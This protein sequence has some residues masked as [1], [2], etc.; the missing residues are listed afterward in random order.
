MFKGVDISVH[1][2]KVNYDGL[3][4]AGIE[5]VIIKATEGVDFIDKRFEEHYENVNGKFPYI[6]SYHY[7]SEKT[8]PIEQANDYYE[9]IKNKG[10]N[11]RPVLD[12][13]ANTYGRNRTQVTDRALLF[14]NQLQALTGIVPIVYTYVSFAEEYLDE[15]LKD[16]PCWIAHYGVDTPNGT[17][18]WGSNYAGHQYTESG[19]LC[20]VGDVNNF[21]DAM[22]SGTSLTQPVNVQHI[23][24]HPETDEVVLQLQRLI[25]TQGFGQIDEDGIKGPDTLSHCPLVKKGAKGDITAWIQLR[26]GLTGDDVDGKFGK[27]TEQAVKDFQAYRGIGADGVVGEDTWRQLLNM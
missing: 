15:R 19:N 1:N 26:V 9:Q 5:C 3:R 4:E 21:Y 14:L 13:E 20:G 8:D 24:M 11:V 12:I 17:H 6:G 25:N 7:F 23:D 10:F 2:D 16:Y 22:L 18:I 27:G